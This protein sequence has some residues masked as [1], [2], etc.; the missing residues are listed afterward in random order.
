M[1]L[2]LTTAKVFFFLS[3][4]ETYLLLVR[5]QIGVFSQPFE[6]DIL[7]VKKKQMNKQTTRISK[8]KIKFVVPFFSK[9]QSKHCLSDTAS[10]TDWL[11]KR[12]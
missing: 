8:T 2:K 5:A 1:F 7:L 4:V 10:R 6:N 12:H 9:M 11:A 3:K